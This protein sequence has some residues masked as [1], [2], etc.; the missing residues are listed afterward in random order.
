MGT[1][2]V[3]PYFDDSSS[4]VSGDA[5]G[6][7]SSMIDLNNPDSYTVQDFGGGNLLYQDRSSGLY[8]DPNDL[9][10]PL[11]ATDVA[12]YGAATNTSGAISP[13]SGSAPSQS[14]LHAPA[15]TPTANSPSSGGM[16]MSGL[17][18]LFTAVGG[19]FASVINPPKTTQGGQ[20]LVYDAVRG[21]YI[22]AS[23]AGQSVTQLSSIPM[24][25]VIGAVAI[26]VGIV[27]LK[28]K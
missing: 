11:S 21:T 6:G 4:L 22:P 20:P 23:A 28:E 10:T 13:V 25:L 8:Y 17:S 3:V 14:S 15:T 16:N 26:V 12:S 2:A 18:G 24:W 5:S 19:A 9:S 27:F 7:G 1:D